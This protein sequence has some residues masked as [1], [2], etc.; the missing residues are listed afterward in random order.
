MQ[1]KTNLVNI[2]S[3]LAK[4]AEAGGINVNI[5][6]N[7]NVSIPESTSKSEI[8]SEDR[9]STTAGPTESEQVVD[10]TG[11]QSE[12]ETAKSEDSAPEQSPSP[13]T[14]SE[15][16]S[17]PMISPEESSQVLEGLLEKNGA[18]ETG[19]PAE[20]AVVSTAEP[21]NEQSNDAES[22]TEAVPGASAEGSAPE[23]KV[24]RPRPR[25]SGVP[26]AGSNGRCIRM[27]KQRQKQLSIM[28]CEVPE[29]L[30]K[31]PANEAEAQKL[32]DALRPYL[33]SKAS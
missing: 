10:A 19:T 1:I 3:D 23:Q 27:C 13:E 18:E 12:A 21:A 33:T 16:Q 4:A 9:P 24:S 11:E 17:S 28:G 29:D 25:P 30:M 6:I 20:K 2:L 5:D 7:V 32:L 22:K 31:D 8:A 26:A 14:A 15:G